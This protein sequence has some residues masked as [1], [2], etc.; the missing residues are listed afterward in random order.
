M[1]SN[2]ESCLIQLGIKECLIPDLR[3]N[4]TMEND[5][6]KILSVIDRCSCVASFVKASDFNGKDVE[7]DLAKLCGNELSLS[8]SKFSAN[9]LG[10]C[11]V[12]LQYLNI[13]SDETNLGNFE[14]VEHSLSQFVKLDASA[15]KALNVFPAGSQNTSATMSVGSSQKCTSLFQLLNK[16]KTNAGVRLLNEWLKQP[17]TDIES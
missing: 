12:L 13:M 2:L 8:V 10:A 5:L 7:S 3:D 16:C 11:N 6:K 4:P 1:F 17:L 15:I 9:A 14:I